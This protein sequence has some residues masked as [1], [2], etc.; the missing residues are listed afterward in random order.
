VGRISLALGEHHFTRELV[1][2]LVIVFATT[3]V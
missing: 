2:L 1:V 3:I